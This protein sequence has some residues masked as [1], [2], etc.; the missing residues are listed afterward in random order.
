M[1]DSLCPGRRAGMVAGPSQS[2]GWS[3]H[4]I[5]ETGGVTDLQ[6]GC[7]DISS[8]RWYCQVTLEDLRL[9]P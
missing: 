4:S 7:R 9:C 5:T 3:S 8:S 2:W 6:G 1:G